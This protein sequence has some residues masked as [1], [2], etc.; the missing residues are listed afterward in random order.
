MKKGWKEI[1]QNLMIA[2][3]LMGEKKS[4]LFSFLYSLVF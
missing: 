4:I 2:Y 3:Y 1:Y